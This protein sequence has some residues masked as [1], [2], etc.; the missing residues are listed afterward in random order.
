LPGMDPYL[1]QFWPEVH[2]SLITYTRDR[3][4]DYLPEELR[5]RVEERVF[6]EAEL[7]QWSVRY[8]DVH[9]VEYPAKMPAGSTPVASAERSVAVA[10]PIS[11][12]VGYE[13]V[14]QGYIE[15]IDAASGN[16]VVTAIEYL[17]P[18]NK[19]PGE[20]KNL[21]LK[22]QKEYQDGGVNF[23]AIDLTRTGQRQMMVPPESI[24]AR[25]RTTYQ[26]GVWRAPK[27]DVLNIYR[28]PLQERLPVIPI[29]LRPADK[30]IALDLQELIDLCY[31]NGRYDNIDYRRAPEPPLS[32]EETAWMDGWLKAKGLR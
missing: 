13:P 26:I 28:A 10:E 8:P 27:S 21:F 6:V 11:I 32:T 15:I 29:P 3:M 19:N 4:R 14:T 18:S 7:D 16:R 24:A 20:G 17:S 31:H 12:S 1:E 2:H 5:A 9:A 23:V 25:F 30:E 22:K